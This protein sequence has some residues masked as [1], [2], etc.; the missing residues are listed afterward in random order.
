M[1]DRLCGICCR[2]DLLKDLIIPM[3]KEADPSVIGRFC[4][5]DIFREI[6]YKIRGR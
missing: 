4:K 3:H 1:A 6:Y 2:K 5:K